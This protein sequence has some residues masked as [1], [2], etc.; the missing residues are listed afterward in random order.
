MTLKSQAEIDE[1]IK[2]TKWFGKM[3]TLS[4]AW[5]WLNIN[6]PNWMQQHDTKITYSEQIGE[7]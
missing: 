5:N 7:D 3:K 1:L 6:I 4:D 2:Y